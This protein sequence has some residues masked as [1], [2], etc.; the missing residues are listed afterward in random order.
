MKL[1]VE[2][3]IGKKGYKTFKNKA[4]AKVWIKEHFSK[5]KSTKVMEQNIQVKDPSEL[6]IGDK[7][8]WLDTFQDSRF[9]DKIK[10]TVTGFKDSNDKRNGYVL[11][12]QDD[13]KDNKMIYSNLKKEGT[14][15]EADAQSYADKLKFMVGDL[16]EKTELLKKGIIDAVND[17]RISTGTAAKIFSKLKDVTI[18]AYNEI[19]PM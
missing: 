12:K 7:V 13:G 19:D 18:R 4:E 1:L 3:K 16:V 17:K 14:I 11:I 15:T 6:K 9:G 10:G 8:S 5:I 2:S